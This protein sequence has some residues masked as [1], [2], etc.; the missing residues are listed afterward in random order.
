MKIPGM[1][2][3]GGTTSVLIAV[4]AAL[5]VDA[6]AE[7]ASVTIMIVVAQCMTTNLPLSLIDI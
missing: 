4:I 7:L 3:A 2:F 6:Q 1:T 5:A